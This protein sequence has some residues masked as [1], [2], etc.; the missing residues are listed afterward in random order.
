VEDDEDDDDEI[1][2]SPNIGGR[3]TLAWWM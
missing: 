1:D 3:T 2:S